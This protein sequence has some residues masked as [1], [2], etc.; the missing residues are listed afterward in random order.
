IKSLHEVTAVK[1]RVTAAKQNLVLFIYASTAS[2]KLVL[3]VK[4]E[5]NILSSYYCLYTVNELWRMRMKQ[6]IQ[7]VDYSLWEVIKNGNA[8]LIT[9]VDKS[10]ETTIT[11]T[12]AKKAVEKRFRG[13]ATTKKT[14][15]NLLK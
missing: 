10:V 9:L 2:V 14:Q 13:N 12:T 3:L 4:I 11:P 15:R 5:E 8:P 6:Y 7:I 1:V